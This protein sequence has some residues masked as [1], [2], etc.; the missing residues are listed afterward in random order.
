MEYGL[1]RIVVVTIVTLLQR[2]NPCFNG[3]W[4]RTKSTDVQNWNLYV[5]ILVLMEYGLGHALDGKKH[6]QMK[7][8]NPCFNGIW[9]RTVVM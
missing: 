9:S 3:I 1:G 8:L 5:L 7:C 6:S 4:S 2:L